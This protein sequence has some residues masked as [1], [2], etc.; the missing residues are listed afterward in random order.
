MH[1]ATAGTPGCFV[2]L[3]CLFLI[4]SCMNCLYILEI[5]P[6][7]SQHLQIFSPVLWVAFSFCLWVFCFVLLFC[8]F[9]VCAKDFTFKWVSFVSF[10][11]DY[12]R[13]WIQEDIAAV[14]IQVCSPCVFHWSFI[15]SGLIF[16]S[17]IH[18]EFIFVYDEREC[19]NF[20]LL[21]VVV[22]FPQHQLLK[23]LSFSPLYILASSYIN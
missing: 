23:R 3:F 18:F 22:Q 20:F 21:Q 15:I 12:S 14:Y 2:C 17:L 9:C 7:W 10:Y 8:F 11:F 5:N 19:S 16:A 6:C 13:R 1:C 4:L